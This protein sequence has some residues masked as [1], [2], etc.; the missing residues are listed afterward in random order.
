MFELTSFSGSLSGHGHSHPIDFTAEV[1]DE[2]VLSVQLAR[3]P[4]SDTAYG[5]Y[6]TPEPT[7]LLDRIVLEGIAENGTTFR[8][9]S[10]SILYFSHGS[11]E[12]QELGFQGQCAVADITRTM[13]GPHKQASKLWL[14]RKF[15]TIHRISRETPLGKVWAGGMDES[16]DSQKA[17]GFL[18]LF[19]PSDTADDAWLEESE[20][21]FIHV[22]RVMSFASSSYL[23]PVVERVFSG[24]TERM[25]V[26]RRGRAV[27]P[28]L[29]PFPPIHLEPIFAVACDTFSTR[30]ETVAKLDAAIRWFVMPAPTF[31]SQLVNAMTSIENILEGELAA[32]S[33]Q[34]ET[35][36]AFKKRVS[37]LR[38]LLTESDAPS[39]MIDKLPELNR[40]AF[41]EQIEALVAEW[42]I[43][44]D[45][46]PDG[47][48][49]A[50]IKVRNHIV[51]TGVIPANVDTESGI[52]GHV[53]WAREIA[54]RLILHM[55]GFV[56]GYQSWL[57]RDKTLHFPT[58]RPVG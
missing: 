54:T 45:D 57:H 48:L 8:S 5:L 11:I 50:L 19:D 37:P 24:T 56:G 51:H 23:M 33:R 12:G 21:F 35:S 29:A 34:F 30:A 28:G 52:P 9:D 14:F 26:V 27:R 39:G 4:F 17:S 47:W 20:R 25:R 42:G 6:H 58:C 7:E 3:L 16:A 1:D 43:V 2:G 15:G 40:R 41:R 36:S 53:I 38:K 31:E 13:A 55:L 10:F 46:L 32:A 18:H 22:L 49:P 44:T